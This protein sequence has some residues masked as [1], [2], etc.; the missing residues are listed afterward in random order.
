MDKQAVIDS[1]RRWI[2]SMVIGLDLCPFARRVFEENKIRYGVTD[3]ADEI[4]LLEDLAGELKALASDAPSIV[5]TTLLIH[6]HAL[7][8]FLDYSDF[9]GSA[10]SLV[11]KLGL[12]GV[13]QIASF[14]PDYRFA[15][16]IA[17]A[18]EN[19]SN[20]SP[21]P[22]LHLLREDSITRVAAD[23]TELLKIPQR[24]GQTLRSLGREKILELLDGCGRPV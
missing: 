4:A 2:R 5:E 10:E 14:H 22:M 15:G 17:G 13:I 8:N 21:H 9:L 23:P 1:T 20:R 19:F 16:T 3:A 11:K 12:R 24:N 6:P 18:V 7:G